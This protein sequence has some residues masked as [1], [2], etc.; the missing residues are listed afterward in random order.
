MTFLS[1][2]ALST[3]DWQQFF[4]GSGKGLFHFGDFLVGVGVARTT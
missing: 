3:P 2:S 4:M 1:S